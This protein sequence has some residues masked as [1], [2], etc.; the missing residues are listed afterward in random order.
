MKVFVLVLIFITASIRIFFWIKSIKNEKRIKQLGGVEYTKELSNLL[1]FFH[2][3]FYIF[4]Y[5][6]ALNEYYE[7]DIFVAL[8]IV[9][10]I[11]AIAVLFIITKDLGVYWTVRLFKVPQQPISTHW[12]YR[13]FR[14][15][16]Y[17]LNIIPE[18]IGLSLMFKAEKTFAILFPIY[19]VLLGIRILLEEHLFKDEYKKYYGR[20]D[21]EK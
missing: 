8:G 12:L 19:A 20:K 9:I 18:F 6:E 7:F 5:Y 4:A 11:F 16:N 21:G 13:K 15:P 17:F 1:I 14:H 3:I 10:Y 2:F